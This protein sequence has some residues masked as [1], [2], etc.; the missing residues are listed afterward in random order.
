MWSAAILLLQIKCTLKQPLPE[1][2]ITEFLMSFIFNTLPALLSV[3]FLLDLKQSS[4]A[5]LLL[6]HVLTLSQ[7]VRLCLFYN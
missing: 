1:K 5:V 7:S 2:N 4:M 6:L 3:F